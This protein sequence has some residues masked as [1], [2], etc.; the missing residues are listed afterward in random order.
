MSWKKNEKKEN[1][2]VLHV[3]DKITLMENKSKAIQS[4]HLIIRMNNDQNAN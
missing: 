2:I 1:Q 4:Y 3:T